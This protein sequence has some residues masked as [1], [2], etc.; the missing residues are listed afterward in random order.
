[1][2]RRKTQI[3]KLVEYYQYL[4]GFGNNLED[5]DLV[6]KYCDNMTKNNMIPLKFVNDR[7][8]DAE[9]YYCMLSPKFEDKV[10]T[11]GQWSRKEGKKVKQS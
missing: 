11:F 3:L 5:I 10:K 7:E 4:K 9:Y 1:M 6:I 8:T 2:N